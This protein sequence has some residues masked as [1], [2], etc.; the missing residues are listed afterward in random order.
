MSTIYVVTK[1]TTHGY[2]SYDPWDETCVLKAFRS[3]ADAV[4]FENDCYKNRVKGGGNSIEFRVEDIEFD[5]AE[6]LQMN[7]VATRVMPDTD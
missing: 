7:Y 3:L 4:A 6:D 2:L 1:T 5:E